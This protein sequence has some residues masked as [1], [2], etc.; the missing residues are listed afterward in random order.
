VARFQFDSLSFRVKLLL[1]PA[2][3]AVGFLLTLL[4][5]MIAGG[6]S[7]EKLRLAE[8]GDGPSL[9]MSRNLEQ[10]LSKIQRAL[11][12]AVAASNADFTQEVEPLKQEF[13]RTLAQGRT[14][15]VV[16]QEE[17]I[18]L[19]RSFNSYLT[20]ATATTRQMIANVRGADLTTSLEAMQTQYRQVRDTLARNTERDRKHLAGAFESAR[21]AQSSANVLLITIIVLF[22]AA[23]IGASMNVNRALVDPVGRALQAAHRLRD[24]DVTVRFETSASDEVGQLVKALGD[25]TRYLQDMADVAEKIAEGDLRS[26]PKPRSEQDRFGI[27]FGEMTRRLALVSRDL[28]IQAAGVAAAARQVSSASSDLSGGTSDVAASVEETLSSLEEMRASIA[29]NSGNSLRM[30][31]MAGRAASEAAESGRSVDST[32]QAMRAIVEKITVIEEISQQTNLLALNAAIEAARA[33]E[34]GRGFA[35]V[36]AEVRKLAE[37]AQNAAADIGEVALRSVEVAEKSGDK[38]K[39]LVPVIQKT[40]HLCQE[41]AAASRELQSGVEQITHAMSRVDHVTQRN[42]ASAEELSATADELS[43]QAGAQQKLVAYFQVAGDGEVTPP[44][45]GAKRA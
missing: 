17:L 41:V 19:E 28:K 45:V 23:L 18:Q 21:Q 36:A 42:S 14:N 35:V 40:A 13:L 26:N 7:A 43:G 22:I 16:D 38:L 24:G 6:R 10:T 27:A 39:Q 44:P 9:E 37:R 33:G 32:V 5:T 20:T 12:D 8:T 29:A 2:V 25:V 1:L 31:E 15:P 11:Q 34:H 4:V 30:E 3:A